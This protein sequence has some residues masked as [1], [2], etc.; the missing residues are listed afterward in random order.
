MLCP[1]SASAA[2]NRPNGLDRHVSSLTNLQLLT[3]P[4]T[5]LVD[6]TRQLAAE[7]LVRFA[8]PVWFFLILCVILALGYFWRSGHA[9]ALRDRLRRAIGNEFLVR[10][11]FGAIIGLVGDLAS[12][13]GQFVQYR[14]LRVEGLSLEL[15]TVWAAH[16]LIGLIA[17]MIAIG[18]IAAIALWLADRSHQWYVVVAFG[19]F[20]ISFGIAFAKPY[21]MK[22]LTIPASR[23][24]AAR[25]QA[26]ELRAGSPDLAVFT[27]SSSRRSE[28][29]DASASGIGP[30]R[31][32]V[33][34]ESLLAGASTGEVAFTVAHELGH[35]ADGD[36]LRLAIFDAVVF[37][38]IS[39]LAVLIADRI[40]FRRDDDPVSRLALV[41]ALIGCMYLLAQPAI[42]AYSRHLETRA[43]AYALAL[44]HDPASGVRSLVRFSDQGLRVVCPDVFSGWY[45]ATHPSIAHRVAAFNHV[46]EACP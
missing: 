10:F 45:F 33:L 20:A 11:Y 31:R 36:P 26:L 17:L 21:T 27:R 19:V 29:G 15:G 35:L 7:R 25:L 38:V 37:I 43:D 32:I 14:L 23:P 42:H 4:A 12:L 13:P 46:P 3:Q 5:Q 39:A 28:E 18:L 30:S 40:G 6:Q 22:F 34:G 24:V 2:S 9:A 41:G 1:A 16:W 44:T 8:E